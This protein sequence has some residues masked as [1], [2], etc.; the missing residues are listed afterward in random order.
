M[1]FRALIL[2]DRGEAPFYQNFWA[3]A[4]HLGAALDEIGRAADGL[5]LAGA[6]IVQADPVPQL[7]DVEMEGREDLRWDKV[8]F[9]FAPDGSSTGFVLPPGVV[10]SAT[11]KDVELHAGFRQVEG[12]PVTRVECAVSAER[13]IRDH[14]HLLRT[15]E[16]FVV[17]W[18]ELQDDWEEAGERELYVNEALDRAEPI[19]RHLESVPD[20]GWRNGH[21]TL[22]AFARAG[23]TNVSL[24]DHKTLR[25]TTTEPALAERARDAFHL[26]GYRRDDQL[27]MVSEGIHHWHH[28]PTSS[29]GRAALIARLLELGFKKWKPGG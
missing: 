28:R 19:V 9:A 23:A 10:R 26:L 18:Y 24:T 27:P 16:P 5:G 3:R 29:L 2:H 17:F 4:D 14:E 12:N 25:V 21:V 13:L 15:F 20:L 22:T 8:R 1:W 6:T 11:G 7:P